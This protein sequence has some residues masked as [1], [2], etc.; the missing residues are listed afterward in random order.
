[1]P[2]WRVTTILAILGASWLAWGTFTWAPWQGMVAAFIVIATGLPVYYY[3]EK[4]YGSKVEKD[5]NS[6][7]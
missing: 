3:W 7:A 2:A 1:M 5:S 4:K 6:V